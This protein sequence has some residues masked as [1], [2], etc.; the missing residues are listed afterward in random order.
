[1]DI[2]A[3]LI[4][5][6]KGLLGYKTD[7]ELQACVKGVRHIVEHLLQT[8]ADINY[9]VQ[10]KVRAALIYHILLITCSDRSAQRLYRL[11]SVVCC[12]ALRSYI[13]GQAS[14]PTRGRH[15]MWKR[16]RSDR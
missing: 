4:A 5:V 6:V 8:G 12:C 1:M 11:H 9:L 13:L 7:E 15:Q 10:P 16:E 2:N 14:S 3:K